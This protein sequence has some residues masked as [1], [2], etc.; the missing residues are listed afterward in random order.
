MH[1]VIP[2]AIPYFVQF[3]IIQ[4]QLIYTELQHVLPQS[5]LVMLTYLRQPAFINAIGNM[6]LSSGSLQQVRRDKNGVYTWA[7]QITLCWRA[8]QNED[9]S[10]PADWLTIPAHSAGVPMDAQPLT[11]MLVSSPRCMFIFPPRGGGAALT[12][13]VRLV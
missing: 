5:G 6:W 11:P 7:H 13:P 3:A 2:A 1:T 9:H 4:I 12:A 10:I 8:L